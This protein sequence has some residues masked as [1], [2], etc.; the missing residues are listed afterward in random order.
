M[1]AKGHNAISYLE[2]YQQAKKDMDSQ[3]VSVADLCLKHRQEGRKE[4]VEWIKNECLKA[5]QPEWERTIVY[6]YW[7]KWQAKLKEWGITN[8]IGNAEL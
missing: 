2:G 8:P 7:N 3:L 5:E 6:L 4:V 1:K